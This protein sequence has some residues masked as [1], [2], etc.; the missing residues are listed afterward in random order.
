MQLV[1]PSSPQQLQQLQHNDS[2]LWLNLRTNAQ[3]AAGMLLYNEDA[4]YPRLVEKR[5]EGAEAR[6]SV[7]EK[8]NEMRKIYGKAYLDELKHDLINLARVSRNCDVSESL[9]AALSALT[10]LCNVAALQVC[11]RGALG[12][13][14]RARREAC[15]PR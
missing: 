2:G 4:L 9:T 12:R 8:D 14:R 10:S 7:F 1:P 3:R 13:P 6:A 15:K 5:G 11:R